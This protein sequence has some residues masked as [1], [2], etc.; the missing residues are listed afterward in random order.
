[1]CELD[2][3]I[4]IGFPLIWVQGEDIFLLGQLLKPNLDLSWAKNGDLFTIFSHKVCVWGGGSGSFPGN[5]WYV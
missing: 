5:K 3:Q 2:H 1:M 4:L